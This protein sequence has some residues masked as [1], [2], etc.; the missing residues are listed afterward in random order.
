MTMP[1]IIR[2]IIRFFNPQQVLP[3]P[4]YS[5]IRYAEQLDKQAQ[6]RARI[7]RQN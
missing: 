4:D 2:K 3:A 7:A 5:T 1:K 6:Y